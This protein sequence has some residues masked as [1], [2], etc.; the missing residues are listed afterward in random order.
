MTTLHTFGCSFTYGL[1]RKPD[2]FVGRTGEPNRCEPWG[3]MLAKRVGMSHRNYARPGSGSKQIAN[4]VRISMVQPDDVAIIAWSGPLRSFKWNTELGQ[5]ETLTAPAAIPW[6]QI[7]YEHE[8]SIRATANFLSNRNIKFL[9]ISALMDYKQMEA[10][11]QPTKQDFE[12]WNWIEWNMF[13]NSLWDICAN[14]WL[15]G[16]CQGYK[17]NETFQEQYNSERY[18]P[19]YADND[20]IADCLHPSQAGHE[21]IAETLLPY[22]QDL[23]EPPSNTQDQ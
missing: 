14:T 2:E 16:L 3:D 17:F 19:E 11:E 12:N 6:Q 7:L 1:I 18:R 20:L 4:S 22:L 8:T 23:L 13:N 9:M 15:T 10:L 21:K 5:Y